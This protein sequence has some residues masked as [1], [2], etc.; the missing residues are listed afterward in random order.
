MESAQINP[1]VFQSIII[2]G[3]KDSGIR[4]ILWNEKFASMHIRKTCAPIT[5]LFYIQSKS[6]T[7]CFLQFCRQKIEKS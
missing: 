3:I 4:Q 5:K 1:P 2:T 7:S 6:A